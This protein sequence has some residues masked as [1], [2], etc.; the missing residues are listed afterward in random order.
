MVQ[1]L[2]A[3]TVRLDQDR[4]LAT[5]TFVNDTPEKVW[6]S[7]DR[8]SVKA[9]TFDSDSFEVDPAN[10]S[11]R[12]LKAMI[13]RAWRPEDLEA[14]NPGESVGMTVELSEFYVFKCPTKCRVRYRAFHSQPDGRLVLLESAFVEW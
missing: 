5:V 4:L 9:S 10:G 13:K 12:Y 2:V 1:K 8:F 14:V 3:L 11:S 7:P 6:L